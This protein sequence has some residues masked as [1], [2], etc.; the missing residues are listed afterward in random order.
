MDKQETIGKLIN[1][2]SLS[3]STATKLVEERIMMLANEK[4]KET[5]ETKL[6]QIIDILREY[7][8]EKNE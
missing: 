4:I 1:D 6:R 5:G 3:T 8:G 7:T 2:A